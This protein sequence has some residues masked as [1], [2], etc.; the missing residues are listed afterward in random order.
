[1]HPNDEPSLAAR[2]AADV[3][4]TGEYW[5]LIPQGPGQVAVVNDTGHRVYQHCDGTTTD[6]AI[7]A[8]ITGASGTDPEVVARDVAAF[9]AQLL[10]AG[11][12][13][14]QPQP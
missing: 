3:Q 6:A 1:M 7:T 5:V 2:A 14:R 9:L 8:A 12:L 10:S 4:R 13:T 11:L